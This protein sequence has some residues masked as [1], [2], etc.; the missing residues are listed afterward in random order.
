MH[1][2]PTIFYGNSMSDVSIEEWILMISLVRVEVPRLKR[3]WKYMVSDNGSNLNTAM[4]AV[5]KNSKFK[6]SIEKTIII[7]EF[8][9]ISSPNL[10][11]VCS[12][13]L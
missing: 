11:E 3:Q 4:V 5:E 6:N 10:R 7:P 9:N 13:T 1:V 12:D 8:M 2:W